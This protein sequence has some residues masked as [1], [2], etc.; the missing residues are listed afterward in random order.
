MNLTNTAKTATKLTHTLRPS[1]HE[2]TDQKKIDYI[3]ELMSKLWNCPNRIQHNPVANPKSLTRKDL[4]ILKKTPYVV[5]EKSDGVRYLLLLG[6]YPAQILLSASQQQHFSVLID[7][8]NRI[9]QVQLYAIEPFFEG[10]LFDGELVCGKYAERH[11]Y[12]IFDVIAYQGDSSIQKENYVKRHE[13][14]S[15]TFL[16]AEQT[17]TML[18]KDT[19]QWIQAAKDFAIQEEKI[20]SIGDE[21]ALSFHSKPCFQ[22][23]HLAV[24]QR[25]IPSLL[26]WSDGLI[27]TPIEEQVQMRGNSTIFKWK[28]NHTIDFLLKAKLISDSDWNLSL[29]HAEDGTIVNSSKNFIEKKIKVILDNEA[30]LETLLEAYDVVQQ[31]AIETIIECHCYLRGGTGAQG[32]QGGAGIRTLDDVK[33]IVCQVIR[34]RTDKKTPNNSKT[35]MQTL[36]NMIENITS[37]ELTTMFLT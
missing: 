33:E 28:E 15:N 34:L 1:E 36:N 29:F 3:F 35:I 24:L 11:I 19:K 21:Y 6:T 23:K 26:H 27:F 7:R 37:Q 22:L 13:I 4:A 14:V 9:F 2:V 31:H 20:V 25:S 12:L 10:S 16:Q 30:N 32:G 17:E 18:T 5:S 8:A